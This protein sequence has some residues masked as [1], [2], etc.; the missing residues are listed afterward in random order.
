[1]SLLSDE[2][3]VKELKQHLKDYFQINDNG[4]V[5]PSL[6]WDG[7]RAVIRGKLIE[8]ASRLRKA[9]LKQQNVLE[10]KIRELESE[11]KKTSD[12]STFLELKKIRYR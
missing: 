1:M 2:R 12:N 7:G 8:I 5:S 6:I 3:V 10:T 11:H 4:E 9:Q